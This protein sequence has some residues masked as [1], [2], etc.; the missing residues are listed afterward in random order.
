MWAINYRIRSEGEEL[1]AKVFDGEHEAGRFAK[2]PP[3]DVEIVGKV[4]QL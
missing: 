4:W 2:N 1:Y 3:P